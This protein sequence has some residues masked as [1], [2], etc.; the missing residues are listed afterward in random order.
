[1]NGSLRVLRFLGLAAVV[2]FLA[3]AVAQPARPAQAVF[4]DSDG[5][6]VLDIGEEIAGSDP[7]DPNSVPESTGSVFLSGHPLCSDGFD[8][9]LDGLTDADDPGCTDSDGDIVSDPAE[10]FLGSDPFDFASFPE[11]SRLDAILDFSGIPIFFCADGV[12]NDLDGLTDADDPGCTVIGSDGDD[13][14]DATEKRYGSDPGDPNSVPEHEGPNPGSCSDGIDNDLDG[15]IDGADPAC[16]APLNDD[17]ADAIVISTLPFTHGPVVMKNATVEQNEPRPSCSF[18]SVEGTVW[19]RFTATEDAV[20]IADTGGS[21]FGTSLAVWR[22]SGLGLVE[23]AC[24]FNFG[25]PEVTRAVFR[26]TAGE[27]YLFQVDGFPFGEALPSLGFNLAV[28]TPPANDDF[29]DATIVDALPFADSVDTSAATTEFGEPRPSCSGEV[30]S[31]VWYSFTPKEDALI[32]ADTTGSEFNAVL[33]VWID[34]PFGLT[35]IACAID[36]SFDG[37]FGVRLAFQAS[38]GETYLIQV[39]RFPFGPFPADGEAF[40]LSFNLSVGVPPANDDFANATAVTTLPF[41]ATFDTLAATKEPGEPTPRCLTFEQIAAT[42]W[43]SFTP[44]ADTII[45]ADTEGTDFFGAA[46]GVYQGSSL[47]DLTQ[48]SCGGPVF[49]YT[50]FAFEASA[51]QTY[52]FQ[53]G[54]LS[55]GGD[56]IIFEEE[57]P[58]EERGVP[59]SGGFFGGGGGS[60]LVFNVDTLDVPSCPAEQFSVPDPLGDT[61]ERGFFGDQLVGPFH[62]V[63]LV[64]GGT[65]D[66]SFCLTLEFAEPIDPPDAGTDRSVQVFVDIDV[67]ADRRTG[68]TSSV[69]F[70][71]GAPAALGVETQIYMAEGRGILA[72][73]FQFF[74]RAEPRPIPVEPIADGFPIPPPPV[75]QPF[76]IALFGETSLTLVIP[77]DAIGGDDSFHFALYVLG[78]SYQPTDCVPNGGFIRSP[79]PAT[80]GDV[81]CDGQVNSLDAILIMQFFARLTFGLPCQNVGDLNGNGSVGPLDALLILQYE[82]GLLDALPPVPNLALSAAIQATAEMLEVPKGLIQLVRKEA[83]DWP[84][85]CLG[86]AEAGESCLTVITPGFRLTLETDEHTVVWRTNSDGST[87]RL[88]ELR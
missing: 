34:S 36:F 84:D 37:S 86:L 41:T 83:Q 25:F 14:D 32:I 80:S 30:T 61:I 67:D 38:A 4:D 76:A 56:V 40:A 7:N 1:M 73:I 82:A 6:G 9:D 11:D 2:A 46:V 8:N 55:F 53:V 52:L 29:A 69:D 79:V 19:Y 49:P 15:L 72:P 66:E 54:S 62:D 59:A 57:S 77:A 18:G 44:A 87:V 3:L 60:E 26:A 17:R 70:N 31:S 50:E 28:G 27:T 33:A 78:A 22:E 68:F 51:G 64:S 58:S 85:S 23:V 20:L 42:A 35:D 63:T 21:D 5:D 71:C 39:D 43:F 12:D 88:E 81:N 48:V 75:E 74:I 65:N 45:V 47:A 24:D 16:S 10:E 13:F